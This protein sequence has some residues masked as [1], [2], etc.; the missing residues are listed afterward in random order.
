[1]SSAPVRGIV[2]QRQ[3]RHHAHHH[4]KQ[5]NQLYYDQDHVNNRKPVQ[6]SVQSTVKNVECS[7]K[8]QVGEKRPK[9]NPIFLWAAQREQK[10]VEVRC[11][12][13]DKRNRIK[14]TKTAQGWRSIPRTALTAHP[15]MESMEKDEREIQVTTSTIS[16]N[17]EKENTSRGQLDI[18]HLDADELKDSQINDAIKLGEGDETQEES[19]RHKHKRK[20]RSVCFKHERK[21]IDSEAE[22][23]SIEASITTTWEMKGRRKLDKTKRMKKLCR[24]KDVISNYK[25]K[26]AIDVKIKEESQ[27]DID[28]ISRVKKTVETNTP[29]KKEHKIYIHCTEKAITSDDDRK[30]KDLEKLEKI[31]RLQPRVVLE[32][33]HLSQLPTRVHR[34]LVNK[35]DPGINAEQ[36]G[37]NTINIIDRIPEHDM[38]S[39]Y[40]DKNENGIDLENEEAIVDKEDLQGI[41]NMLDTNRLSIQINKNNSLLKRD[42]FPRSSTKLGVAVP[43]I[44]Q[45]E[46]NKDSIGGSSEECTKYTSDLTGSGKRSN[47]HSMKNRVGDKSLDKT[48]ERLEKSI[49]CK[50]KLGI[51]P[52]IVALTE[53]STNKQAPNLLKA[54]SIDRA[55]DGRNDMVSYGSVSVMCETTSGDTG[56]EKYLTE[57]STT[58]DTLR[59]A[60][61]PSVS[62]ATYSGKHDAFISAISAEKKI[63]SSSR[64]PDS[65][66]EITEKMEKSLPGIPIA[67]PTCQ[68]KP[69][70]ASPVLQNRVGS[71]ESTVH[72]LK[73]ERY[74]YEVNNRDVDEEGNCHTQVLDD[75]MR[76]NNYKKGRKYIHQLHEEYQNHYN[77]R[78]NNYLVH[79]T[80]VPNAKHVLQAVHRNS[81]AQAKYSH[82]YRYQDIDN[83]NEHMSDKFHSQVSLQPCGVVYSMSSSKSSSVYLERLLPS[84]PCSVSCSEDTK[85]DLTIKG[86]LSSTNTADSGNTD[87]EKQESDLKLDYDSEYS[88]SYNH[89]DETF[90]NKTFNDKFISNQRLQILPR[91]KY[92][93]TRNRGRPMSSGNVHNPFAINC[94]SPK[95]PLSAE[96]TVNQQ[97]MLNNNEY[98]S[99]VIPYMNQKAFITRPEIQ[100]IHITPAIFLD[101]ASQLRELIKTSGHLIPDPMLVP[102]DY[103][104][105]LAGAPLTEIPKLL[106]TR[107]ELRLPEALSRPEL[108]RDPDLLVISLAHLQHV[109]DHGEGPDDK[110]F[111]SSLPMPTPT[112]E[113]IS[114]GQLQEE[115]S[116]QQRPKLSCK[117]IGK[118]MP[119]PMD[120][121]NNHKINPHPPLLR[122]CNGLLKQESTVSSTA[123]SPDE[124]QLWHPLF[125]R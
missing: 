23:F 25:M 20:K 122:V 10:I 64:S 36:Y 9:V 77:V 46:K 86:I 85:N 17:E 106:A 26:N 8:E 22:E 28:S 65:E 96:W 15:S 104:P 41:L 30:C 27:N 123:N 103:L 114:M 125:G 63:L 83:F 58:L 115:K 2:P 92:L 56:I 88:P 16:K 71:H 98:F 29:E 42:D 35:A 19:E 48:I 33:L 93:N 34:R 38:Q 3:R 13:Y 4:E 69:N 102:R 109:L 101:P 5:R 44:N 78:G 39:G 49:N 84:P 55:S 100:K 68:E 70:I 21:K 116:I 66:T 105:L 120:L 62:L 6:Q 81:E 117:P 87:K 99:N 89:S 24:E 60:P 82:L 50:K 72:F 97:R 90:F 45:R 108:L 121:S 1:M 124:S 61:G 59:M 14:L 18:K 110:I 73:N 53:Y 95:R 12:D 57:T 74:R 75:T 113:N 51:A 32:Q 43:D 54:N 37:G 40:H 91:E 107:P 112:S 11:E 79:S 67:V 80:E 111:P 52:N 76:P 118:L 7:R 119:T 94:V 31:C 47:H